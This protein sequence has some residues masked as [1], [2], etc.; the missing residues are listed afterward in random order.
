[1]F[2]LMLVQ[3]YTKLIQGIDSSEKVS[4]YGKDDLHPNELPELT[5]AVTQALSPLQG[6]RAGTTLDQTYRGLR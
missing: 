1:M 5:H 4:K 2:T 3:T 6:R